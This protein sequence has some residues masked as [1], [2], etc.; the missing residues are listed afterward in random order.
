M[1]KEN[2]A[3]I[4]NGILLSHKEEWKYGFCQEMNVTGKYHAKWNKPAPK[5][6]MAQLFLLF[7]HCETPWTRDHLFDPEKWWDWKSCNSCWQGARVYSML[8]LQL[9]DKL[10]FLFG[11]FKWF[12]VAALLL[13][14]KII[15]INVCQVLLQTTRM[16]WWNVRKTRSNRER[17]HWIRYDGY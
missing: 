2:V 8:D 17:K 11:L 14:V 4:H 12:Q 7:I 13:P 10:H 5:K 16:Q 1:V 9:C 3:Y 15:L 6:P